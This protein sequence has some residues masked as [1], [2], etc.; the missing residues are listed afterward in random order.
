MTKLKRVFVSTLPKHTQNDSESYARHVCAASSSFGASVTSTIRP[1]VVKGRDIEGGE[2][3]GKGARH[4]AT[5]RQAPSPL[6]VD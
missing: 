4:R 5:L 3:E 2:G 1:T 6:S